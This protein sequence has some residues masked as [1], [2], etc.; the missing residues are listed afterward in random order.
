MISKNVEEYFGI[1]KCTILYPKDLAQLCV[2]CA[3]WPYKKLVLVAVV[4]YEYSFLLHGKN[5]Y[6][7]L[8]CFP[9]KL[10]QLCAA[11]HMAGISL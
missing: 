8:T 10:Y 5:L 4:K 3:C 2:T 6:V 7:T 11:H 1:V 9:C